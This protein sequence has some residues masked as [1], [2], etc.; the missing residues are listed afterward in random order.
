[1]YSANTQNELRELDNPN[2][3]DYIN[4]GHGNCFKILKI[5]FQV[6]RYKKCRY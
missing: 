6:N 5:V 1:M 2:E 3:A 4:I